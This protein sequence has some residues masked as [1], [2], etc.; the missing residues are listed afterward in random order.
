MSTTPRGRESCDVLDVIMLGQ[1]G[2]DAISGIVVLA[3]TN[4]ID[5][6]DPALLRPG[7]F[8]R[9]ILIDKV[10]APGRL[11]LP[12][13]RADC[14]VRRLRKGAH[15]PCV[16]Q[17]AKDPGAQGPSCLA[18]AA[19]TTECAGSVRMVDRLASAAHRCTQQLHSAVCLLYVPML[20]TP[21][22]AHAALL[23]CTPCRE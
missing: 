18:Y 14:L 22:T 4:R 12:S 17:A 21:H 3:G 20:N 2:F 10:P 19:Q 5:I 16:P 8:D 13:H 7:R 6:I 23:N 1:D 15:S 9:H 11:P